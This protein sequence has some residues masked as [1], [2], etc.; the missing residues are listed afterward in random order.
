MIFKFASKS[1]YGE[2]M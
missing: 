2:F 1:F